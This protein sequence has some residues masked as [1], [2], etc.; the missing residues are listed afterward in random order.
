MTPAPER[1]SGRR[2]R[3]RRSKGPDGGGEPGP[4]GPGGVQGEEYLSPNAVGRELGISGE[5]VKQWIY[6]RRLPATKLPNGY[7]RISRSDLDRFLRERR[8]GAR[9]R[10]LLVGTSAAAMAADFEARGFHPL[11][12]QNPV[13]AVVRATD[14]KPS[15]A[16]IDLVS[17]GEGGWAAAE[18]LRA[19]K[20][21]RRLPV[22]LVAAAGREADPEAMDRAVALGIQGY[23]CGPAGP[24][25][26]MDAVEGLIG[27]RRRRP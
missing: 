20:G 24:D 25:E 14:G 18:K 6:R 7:W 2:D 19:T 5:A 10:I 1:R 23:L 13:D 4:R 9:Q 8:E 15:A 22:L 27:G 17:L 26:V 16:V 3:R 12:A 11:V 21:A